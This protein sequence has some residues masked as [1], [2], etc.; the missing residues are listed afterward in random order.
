MERVL[1]ERAER[2]L[3]RSYGPGR[4]DDRYELDGIDYPIGYVRWTE[5]RNLACF[6]DL[7]A[8]GQLDLS[9]LVSGTFPVEQA[10]DVYD[11]LSS[12][13]L[14]GVG[15]LFEY[16]ARPEE[17]KAQADMGEANRREELA[18]QNGHAGVMTSRAPHRPGA[19]VGLGFIGAGNYASSMLLP[20]LLD[21]PGVE[22]RHVATNRSLSA[23]DAKRRFG[24]TNASTD[25][26]AVLADDT[27]DVVFV[28]T[29]HHSHA[30]L[31]CRALR[32]GK[33]VFVEKPLALSESG[34][35]RSPGD[36]QVDG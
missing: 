9:S 7:L 29:R 26:E 5:R 16:P 24:F 8:R 22:L 33:A 12:G 25:A 2:P 36:D 15:F 1:R 20:H 23:Q 30:E 11:R 18:S 32:A 31:T 19:T 27:V 4:Y 28:V 35:R 21:K 6:I 3:P 14:H 17:Q 10:V 13:D 34:A